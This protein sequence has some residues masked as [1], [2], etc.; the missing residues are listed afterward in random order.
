MRDDAES[1]LIQTTLGVTTWWAETVGE[2]TL[3]VYQRSLLVVVDGLDCQV[4]L[5]YVRG[6]N[7][8]IF[9]ISFAISC[10]K[11]WWFVVPVG[12]GS[13]AGRRIE[14][15]PDRLDWTDGLWSWL[16]A[17]R[18]NRWLTKVEPDAGG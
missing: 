1:V 17:H 8:A 6:E 7:L 4:R 3:Q 13:G 14:R 16:F 12:F 11:R 15:R 10:R 5:A 9:A 18:T 2:N